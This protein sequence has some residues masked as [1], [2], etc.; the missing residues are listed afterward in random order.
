MTATVDGVRVKLPASGPADPK[1]Y[2]T[3]LGLLDCDRAGIDADAGTVWVGNTKDR[4]RYALDLAVLD[5]LEALGWVRMDGAHDELT[6]TPA[7]RYWCERFLKLNGR[8]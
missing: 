7:G 5:E 6:V 8:A 1:L 4:V 3:A 2:V